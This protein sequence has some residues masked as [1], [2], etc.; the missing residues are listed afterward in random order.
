MVE[1]HIFRPTEKQE[2]IEFL[3]LK[4]SEMDIYPGVWQMVTGAVQKNERANHTALREIHEETGLVP[5]KMWVVPF[6]NSFYSIKRD[7][8]C[9]VPVFAACISGNESVILS[10]EH[11]EYQWVDKNTA[12]KLLA[13]PGQRNSVEVIYNYFTHERSFLNFEEINIQK[14]FQYNLKVKKKA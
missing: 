5:Q 14:D 10:D 11:S 6:V 12:V 7:H 3:L 13:W 4:R 8:I 9:L 1:A 2:E